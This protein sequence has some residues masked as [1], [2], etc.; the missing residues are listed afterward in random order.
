MTDLYSPCVTSVSPIQKP[1][2]MITR[3][4]GNSLA[5]CSA[6]PPYRAANTAAEPRPPIVNSPAET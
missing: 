4:D 6:L 5:K 1:S 2:R 3:C